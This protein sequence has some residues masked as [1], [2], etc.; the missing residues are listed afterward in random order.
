MKEGKSLVFYAGEKLIGKLTASASKR[1]SGGHAY[2]T[3]TEINLVNNLGGGTAETL[4]SRRTAFRLE[5]EVSIQR[6][7]SVTVQSEVRQDQV[8]F[9]DRTRG[10][11]VG[12][13]TRD[14]QDTLTYKAGK[15]RLVGFGPFGPA[16]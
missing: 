12:R 4:T 13:V 6:K 9:G 5:G 16:L 10:A 1:T 14:G 3:S 7:G 2:S 11:L 15:K 8:N